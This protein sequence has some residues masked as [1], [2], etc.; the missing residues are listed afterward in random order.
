MDVRWVS[1]GRQMAVGQLSDGR[2]TA[3]GPSAGRQTAIRTACPNGR[4]NGRLNG[5]Q[6][7]KS[8]PPLSLGREMTSA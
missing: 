7:A 3:V 6:L 5:G 8:I 1:D 2:R 4:P